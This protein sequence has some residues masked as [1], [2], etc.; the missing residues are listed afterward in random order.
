M[1]WGLLL[2]VKIALFQ[3]CYKNGNILTTFRKSY[4]SSIELLIMI[5]WAKACDYLLDWKDIYTST[6]TS[7]FCTT[8]TKAS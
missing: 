6:S 3:Q 7:V 4:L 5:I 8:I 2:L 1:T